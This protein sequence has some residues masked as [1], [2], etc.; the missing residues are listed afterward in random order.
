MFSFVH[1]KWHSTAFPFI[2]FTSEWIIVWWM[3]KRINVHGQGAGGVAVCAF[4]LFHHPS[5]HRSTCSI[6]CLNVSILFCVQPANGLS[7]LLNWYYHAIKRDIYSNFHEIMIESV[8]IQYVCWWFFFLFSLSPSPPHNMP[9]NSCGSAR[10]LGTLFF[11]STR[12]TH[13]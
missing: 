11:Y 4:F 3:I 7:C 1:C 12:F 6:F 13:P 2:R 8:K 10:L 5:I 9:V